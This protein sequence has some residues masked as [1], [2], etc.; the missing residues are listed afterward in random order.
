MNSKYNKTLNKKLFAKKPDTVPTRN[1]YGSGLVIAGKKDSQ[2]MVLCCDLTDSTRSDGFQ[3][4]YPERFVEIG[5]AEQ[6]MAGVAAGLALEGKVPFCSSY[7]VFNP[8]RNW[9]QVRVSVCYNNANVKIVGAHAGIS[10]GPDGATHQALE[11][12][13]TMRV[14]PNMVVLA[15]CDEEETEKAT[16]A[17]AAHKGPVYLRFGRNAT[18]VITTAKTPFK[19]G[20]ALVMREGSDATIVACGPL[21]YE[22]LM[23]AERLAKENIEVEVINSVSIKPLDVKTITSSA[24]KTGCVVTVEE[25]QIAG[26]LGGAVAET[27][28]QNSPVPIEFVG[29]IDSFGESG[30]P[31]ELMDKYGMG[32]DDVVGAVRKVKK[33]K[34][35]LK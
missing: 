17:A 30:K 25:H 6:N 5:V 9:D 35:L 34:S 3:K 15:P 18:P 24:K 1:G 12:I 19:I 11:D 28:A 13:A 27:L 10:V 20:Q 16:L 32:V 14:L 23:A 31:Q 4:A 26:G 33:R 29:V 8:G 2:V 22:V 7:A 21:V